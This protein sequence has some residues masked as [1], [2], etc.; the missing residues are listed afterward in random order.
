[1]QVAFVLV[2]LGI[3]IKMAFF[4][5]HAVAQCLLPC[6]YGDF[7]PACALGDQ[8]DDLRDDPDGPYGLRS[9]FFIRVNPLAFGSSVVGRGR[10]RF[11]R[12]NGLGSAG[13]QAHAR[14]PH[15]GGGRI[16]GGGRLGFQLLRNDRLDLSYHQ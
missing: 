1:M 14:L 4:P 7:L 10:H 8:G 5:L 16:H 3:L 13:D 6:S 11:G 2:C 12:R 9:G 15:R